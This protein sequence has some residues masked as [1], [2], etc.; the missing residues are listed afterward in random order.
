MLVL[1]AGEDAGGM[2][3]ARVCVM[4]VVGWGQLSGG[5]R[6]SFQRHSKNAVVSGETTM[7]IA[8]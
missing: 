3:P 5:C 1:R 8:Q 2:S 4:R 6:V 7:S